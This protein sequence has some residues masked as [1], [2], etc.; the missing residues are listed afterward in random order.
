MNVNIV[1]VNFRFYCVRD[2]I[3]F[4]LSFFVVAVV[5]IPLILS[6]FCLPVVRFALLH[7]VVACVKM[8]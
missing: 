8:R 1:Y 2:T 7:T 4:F 6:G 5:E 3:Y